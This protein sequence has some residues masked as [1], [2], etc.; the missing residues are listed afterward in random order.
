MWPDRVSNPGSLALESDVL[1]TALRGPVPGRYFCCVSKMT[2]CIV[3]RCFFGLP[4]VPFVLFL[5]IYVC[6]S[7]QWVSKARCGI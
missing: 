2:I 4:C 7:S 6:V 3:K 1:P 5:S